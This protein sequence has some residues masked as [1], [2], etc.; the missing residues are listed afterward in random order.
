VKSFPFANIDVSV[1]FLSLPHWSR[2]RR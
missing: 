1:T 2:F